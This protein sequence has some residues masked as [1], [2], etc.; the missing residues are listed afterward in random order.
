M[1]MAL[2][3]LLERDLIEWMTCMT[4]QAASGG[5]AQNMRRIAAADGRG[6]PR[7][8]KSPG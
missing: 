7:R 1:V 3:G 6:P 5:G 4:Y 2:A 8:E